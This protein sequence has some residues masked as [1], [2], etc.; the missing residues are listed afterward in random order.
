[1]DQC[2]GSPKGR[3]RARG[4]HRSGLFIQS[5]LGKARGSGATETD[6]HGAGAGRG[7]KKCRLGGSYHLEPG[8]SLPSPSPCPSGHYQHLNPALHLQPHSPC[9]WP[10]VSLTWTSAAFLTGSSP[11]ALLPPPS[12][13]G[14]LLPAYNLNLIA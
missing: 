4:A 12:S 14:Y 13:T 5:R 9:P 2:L 8:V 3:M 10:P 11:Q 7:S 6:W 1:M